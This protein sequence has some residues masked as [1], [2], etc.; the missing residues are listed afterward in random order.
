[1]KTRNDNSRLKPL[2]VHKDSTLETFRKG[3]FAIT[4][5]VRGSI[6]LWHQTILCAWKSLEHKLNCSFQH[7]NVI[8]VENPS[9]VHLVVVPSWTGHFVKTATI[10]L[11]Q[12]VGWESLFIVV[13]RGSSIDLILC[14]DSVIL[15]RCNVKVRVVLFRSYH[16]TARDS[17]HPILKICN[18]S[19]TVLILLQAQCGRPGFLHLSPDWNPPTR[20]WRYH[21]SIYHHTIRDIHISL[22][23][24]VV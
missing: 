16:N 23:S 22:L 1:M 5:T 17:K 19:R 6:R 13:A 2:L 10:F 8:T 11:F 18:L 3:T 7:F 9:D 21:I 15:S 12:C 20:A 14:L 4:V 24:C